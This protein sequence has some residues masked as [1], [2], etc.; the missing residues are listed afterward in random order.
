MSSH[1]VS[2]SGIAATPGQWLCFLRLLVQ[3]GT[4]AYKNITVVIRP[5]CQKGVINIAGKGEKKMSVAFMLAPQT[6]KPTCMG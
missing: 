3:K 6:S 2:N 1:P 5:K 4:Q